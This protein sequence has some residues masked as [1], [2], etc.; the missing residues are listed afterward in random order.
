ME[1]IYGTSGNLK[2]HIGRDSLDN[3]FDSEKHF[4]PEVLTPNT[5]VLDIGCGP[6]SLSQA[7]ME[8]EPT[9]RYTGIDLDEKVIDIGKAAYP[10]IE[11]IRGHFPNDF[12]GRTFDVVYTTASV[13]SF[14]D[15]WRDPLKEFVKFGKKYIYLVASLRLSGTTVVDDELS[16]FY[17]LDSGQR[18]L[19]VVHNLYEL[20]N[21]CCTEQI[22]AKSIK[23][24]G[25]HL[26]TGSTVYYPL[27][28][29]EVIKASVLIELLPEDMQVLRY[30]GEGSVEQTR[31]LLG[32]PD[33]FR[34]QVE[35][36]IDGQR[37][38]I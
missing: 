24:W 2:A 21:F 29:N 7:F 32:T 33:S 23:I 36:V 20:V 18:Q 27:P 10:D 4:L 9:T 3:L 34:T 13:F 35:V 26:T 12:E 19:F 31:E 37:I 15:N 5:T 22:R 17:Y 28:Q 11:L 8:I 14:V 25:Y 30:G 38:D 16:Y 1:S 6:G